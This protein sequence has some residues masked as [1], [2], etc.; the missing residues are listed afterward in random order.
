MFGHKKGPKP[1]S[2]KGDK[3]GIYIHIPFCRSKCDYCDFYSLA[4]REGQMDAY[5]KALLA[6]LAETAPL[7]QGIPVDSIYF[8]GGTPSYYG[9]KRLRELLGAIQKQFQVEK[10]AEITLE[11]NPDSVTLQGLKALRKAGF[12]RLSMGMQS[13]N[14]EELTAIHRPHTSHQV[15][16]AV[17]AAKKARFKNLSLDLIYGLPGQTMDSWKATVEHALSLIPQHLSCYGLKVEEGTPLC[18]RVEAGEQLPDDDLQADEYLWTVGRL[19]RAGYPQ[20]EISNFAKPGYESRHNLRY[21]LTQPYIGFGPGAHS[22]FG[23]RRYSFVRD[24]DAYIDG[25]LHGGSIIDSEELIPRRERCGEYLML[26]LRTA[27]GIE[28]WE[29]RSD[30]FM[31]FAPLEE[32]LEEFQAQGW[33]QK[34]PEGRWRLTPKGFLVSNQLIGDLMERQRPADLGDLL[35][36]AREQYA[37][38]KD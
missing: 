10:G 8:G 12:N 17:A 31:D 5:Q 29:Y 7:A 19:E 18:A 38:V 16:E 9:E 6:H 2:G 28:E 35:P 37:R 15:D 25:V 21:W 4:G 11:A 20:Y 30:Y 27:R 13:A 26:R 33:A 32:R 36:K 23:G 14:Q 24:L 34:T 22:D 1:K 3:L